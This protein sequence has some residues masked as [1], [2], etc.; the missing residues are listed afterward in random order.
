MEI[1]VSSDKHGILQ[2]S[3][4]FIDDVLGRPTKED[5]TCLGIVT[6]RQKHKVPTQLGGFSR[7][8][9][10]LIADLFNVEEAAAHA[11]IRFADVLYAIDDC[12]T[13]SSGDTIIIR[14]ADPS[15][16]R[17]VGL[18]KVMLSQV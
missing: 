7:G 13:D 16:R 14:F 17:D 18:D 15:D 8:G 12:G 3:F 9:G 6:G 2:V 5:C 11:D 10:L 4:D 1:D